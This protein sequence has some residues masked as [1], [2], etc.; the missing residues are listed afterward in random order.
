MDI[1]DFDG[2]LDLTHALYDKLK[3]ATCDR[4]GEDI[5]LH[6]YTFHNKD[7]TRQFCEKCFPIVERFEQEPT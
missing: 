5:E 6:P 4:C 3:H 1:P 7:D 2:L